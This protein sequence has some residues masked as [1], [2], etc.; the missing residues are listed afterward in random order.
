VEE[1]ILQNIALA[2]K[3]DKNA[4]GFLY[5]EFYK[6]LHRFVFYKV[7]DENKADDIVSEVFLKWYESLS[8]YEVKQKPL[9]YLYTIA[10][11]LIINESQKKKADYFPEDAEEF[12]ESGEESYEDIL[13]KE[14]NL[15]FIKKIIEENLGEL[16]KD[17]FKL[18][19][20]EGLDNKEIADILNKQENY[21]RQIEFR[22]LKKIKQKVAELKI[23]I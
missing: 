23:N 17:L 5:Q 10:L 7:R 11:R 22:A 2:K 3:G 9:N 18:K 15:D 14:Y 4:F 6:P 13:D 21:I 19:F 16:E 20:Q 8:R 12:L 1:S